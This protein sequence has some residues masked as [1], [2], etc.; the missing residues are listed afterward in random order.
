MALAAAM[1]LSVAERG[2]TEQ[3]SA[4][5]R[6]LLAQD[7][8]K[9]GIVVMANQTPITQAD[10]KA[11]LP[12]LEKLQAQRGGPGPERAGIDEKAAAD[13]DVQLR[14]AL[15]PKLRAAVEAVRLVSARTVIC[16]GRST[17]SS[18]FQESVPGATMAQ[19]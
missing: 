10:A 16:R 12:I 8:T 6:A 11:V 15:S 1:G 9:L 13:L 3:A 4:P 5:D 2:Q 7:V 19:R 17:W 14:A 18:R